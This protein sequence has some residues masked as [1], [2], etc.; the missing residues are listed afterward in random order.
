MDIDIKQLRELMK[1][2]K[3]LGVTELELEGPE[4]RI[5]LRRGSDE[6]SFATPTMMQQGSPSMPPGSFPPPPIEHAHA[7]APAIP[8]DDENVVFVT[9]PF[10]GTFYRSPSPDSAAFTDVGQAI[11]PGSVLCIVEAM[12]LMNEIESEIAGTVI[13]VMVENGKPVEFG[14]KL[15]KV[16]KS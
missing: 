16:K 2:M 6:A 9:S 13:E 7:A 10:V 3:Q 4:Q 5:M 12:K 11:S 14:D 15:F 8:A 1:A